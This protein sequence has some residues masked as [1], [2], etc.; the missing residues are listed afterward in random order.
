MSS[1]INL[2]A[3]IKEVISPIRS[4]I[5]Q[6]RVHA[7]I[8][9]ESLIE[10]PESFNEIPEDTASFSYK[11]FQYEPTKNPFKI[12]KYKTVRFLN[13]IKD[14]IN[15]KVHLINFKKRKIE[16]LDKVIKFPQNPPKTVLNALLECKKFTYDTPNLKLMKD[17][18]GN[19][20]I[21]DLG[22]RFAIVANN[23]H[24]AKGQAY[25]IKRMPEMFYGIEHKELCESLDIL[26]LYL[27][28]DKINK[29]SIGKKDF[30]AKL[31]GQGCNND[32]YLI[33]DKAGN[34]VCLR[35]C[36]DPYNLYGFGHDIY[37]EVAINLEAQK[38]GVKN[39]AKL[40]MA[41]PVGC[42]VKS[43]SSKL[44]Y[45][46]KGAWQIVEYADKNKINSS[47][48]IT[49][50]KWL[51]SKGLVHNDLPQYELND[52][53]SNIIG[54]TIV[55]LGGI[56]NTSTNLTNQHGSAKWLLKGYTQGYTAK[57]MLKMVID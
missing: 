4:A 39:I 31:I 21:Y 56:Q 22:L 14:L 46:T 50:E 34:K 18:Y 37:S 7:Q 23:T 41:N 54:G 44:G 43:K 52:S 19:K 12:L 48:G 49:L 55:D 27:K 25:Y 15:P 13:Y 3:H 42:F 30:T 38:A 5:R 20:N 32:I 26:N 29:F 33:E 57:D 2:K 8:K 47:G 10:Q 45:E 28:P 17:Y 1:I 53:L 51:E 36:R 35:L 24:A 9:G 11:V 6:K 16:V 40:Y